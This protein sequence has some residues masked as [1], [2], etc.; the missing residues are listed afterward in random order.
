MAL[1]VIQKVVEWLREGYPEG[2]PTRD[3]IPLLALLSRR[4]TSEEVAQVTDELIRDGVLQ[5][6]VSVTMIE[7][8]L[9]SVTQQPALESDIK[10]IADNLEHVGWVQNWV[11]AGSVDDAESSNGPGGPNSPDS[12]SGAD[13]GN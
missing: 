10:R 1:D 12:A 7:E 8:A 4:L 3:Y 5:G 6:S 13:K 11:P 9:S 2:V